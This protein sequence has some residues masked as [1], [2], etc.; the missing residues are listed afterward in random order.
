M[1][2]ADDD[3]PSTDEYIHSGVGEQSLGGF[4]GWTAPND[5]VCQAGHEY[6]TMTCYVVS[7]IRRLY[8]AWNNVVS[9]TPGRT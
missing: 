2:E 9:T 7:G 1:V 8:L 6:D 5:F 3:S 4:A